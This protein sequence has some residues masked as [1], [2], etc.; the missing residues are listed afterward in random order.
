MT[1]L[2]HSAPEA[3]PTLALTA[4]EIAVLDRLV[5]DK[6][7]ARRKTLSHYLRSRV[8]GRRPAKLAH[9]L[10]PKYCEY[11]PL[12]RQSEIYAREGAKAVSPGEG[13]LSRQ[14]GPPH[15]R[16][17]R[18]AKWT[19]RMETAAFTG[20]TDF[21]FRLRPRLLARCWSGAIARAT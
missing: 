20:F 11:L 15:R 19:D 1:M 6:P 21:Q 4:L 3:L 16:A 2:N 13:R 7:N 10:A 12:C 5:N 14:G 17:V 8:A 9:L 18:S